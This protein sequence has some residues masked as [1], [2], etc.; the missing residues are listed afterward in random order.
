MKTLTELIK[1]EKDDGLI[2]LGKLVITELQ[3][4]RLDPLGLGEPWTIKRE[5]DEGNQ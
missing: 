1:Q 2:D 3:K 4:K 5:A